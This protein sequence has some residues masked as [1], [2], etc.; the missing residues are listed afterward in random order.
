MDQTQFKSI[1]PLARQV[2]C[3]PLNIAMSEFGIDTPKRQ[4]MFLATLAHESKQLTT[5]TE[6]LFYSAAG[7]RS[8][9]RKYFTDAECEI[10]AKHPQ[11]IAN[12][13]YAN[14]GGNGSEASG[15]GWAFRGAGGI[16]LTFHDNHKAC[17]DHFKIPMSKIGEWLRT[18]E[19]AC[20]SAGWFWDINNINKYADIGD[21]DGVC[22][23]TN[24]G[25]KTP[26]IGDSIGWKE[27]VAQ[28]NHIQKVI[29]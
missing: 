12:R 25:K 3:V 8:T 11:M 1:M 19:G 23:T 29:V 14:R 24:R 4:T 26:T 17:A 9:F 7:L 16:Q 10:F 13:V 21:F 18:P 6:N 20:H 28:L 2:F 22:D 5:L 15:D 27:R